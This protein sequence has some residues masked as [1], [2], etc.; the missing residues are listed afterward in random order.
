[1]LR[2][3]LRACPVFFW[4]TGIAM[5]VGETGARRQ[6]ATMARA[7]ASLA[8]RLYFT[9]VTPCAPPFRTVACTSST[10]AI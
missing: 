1:M 4:A 2:R 7:A 5:P 3:F 10:A 6:I 8:D 9:D